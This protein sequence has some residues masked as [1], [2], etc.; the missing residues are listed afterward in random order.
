M[1]FRLTI[2][3]CRPEI[4]DRTSLAR[5]AD[6]LFDRHAATEISDFSAVAAVG[7]TMEFT[8]RGKPF[9]YGRNAGECRTRILRVDVIEASIVDECVSTCSSEIP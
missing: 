4:H 2:P 5:E 6:G 7:D 1:R 8:V 9:A 3:G